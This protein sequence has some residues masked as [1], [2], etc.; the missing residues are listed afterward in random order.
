MDWSL[1]DEFVEKMYRRSGSVLS[2]RYYSFGVKRF[3]EYCDEKH[4]KPSSKNVYSVLD[5][6]VSSLHAEKLKPKTIADYI[7]AVRKFLGYVGLDIE[8]SKFRAKVIMPRVTKIEDE[9]LTIDNVRILL[10]KGRPNIKVRALILLLLSSGM[11]IGEALSIR[12]GDLNLEGN[13]A[14]VKIKAEYAKTRV[15]RLAYVSDEAK[16]ALRPI[17]TG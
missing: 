15:S 17:I 1:A 3:R 5:G 9:P 8:D 10:T 7:S 4:I 2:Q 11:R 12:V 6:F 13:P 14:T 16:E